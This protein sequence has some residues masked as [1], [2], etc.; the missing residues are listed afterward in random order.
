M[1]RDEVLRRL[2]DNVA[3]LTAFGVE[4]IALFGSFARGDAG[5][6]SDLDFLVRFRE[7]TFDNY[8]GL[9]AIGF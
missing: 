4:D 5:E 3:R 9:N 6:G 7:K 8:A 1:T 2:E